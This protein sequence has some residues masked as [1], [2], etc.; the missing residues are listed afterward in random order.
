MECRSVNCM[1]KGSVFNQS[2]IHKKINSPQLRL[3]WWWVIDGE[4][5]CPDFQLSSS[6]PEDCVM[7]PA[8]GWPPERRTFM[9][10]QLLFPVA[11]RGLFR[12][13]RAKTGLWVSISY[14]NYLNYAIECRSSP[15]LGFFRHTFPDAVSLAGSSS[16]QASIPKGSPGKGSSADVFLRQICKNFVHLARKRTRR[17]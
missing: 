3:I 17:T 16:R 14:S 6:G 1:L 11:T 7:R 8:V 12:R 4:S 9:H 10:W 13:N 5:E 2:E 15:D